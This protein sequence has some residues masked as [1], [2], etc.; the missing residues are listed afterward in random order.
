MTQARLFQTGVKAYL[1]GSSLRSNPFDCATSADAYEAWKDGWLE[2]SHAFW[3]AHHHEA[4]R[5][6]RQMRRMIRL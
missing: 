6:S 4:P 3:R 5:S 1:A 2:A